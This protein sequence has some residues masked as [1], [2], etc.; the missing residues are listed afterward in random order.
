MISCCLL[1]VGRRVLQ[2]AVQSEN[3]RWI[4]DLVRCL[5]VSCLS[6]RDIRGQMTAADD[7][8]FAGQAFEHQ[9]EVDI[10]VSGQGT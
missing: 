1:Q 7:V 9:R 5:G 3:E 6:V 2:L 4:R 10:L 8:A